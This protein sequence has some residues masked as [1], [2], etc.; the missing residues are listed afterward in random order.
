MGLSKG[1]SFNNA[2]DKIAAAVFF[3]YGSKTILYFLILYLDK[4]FCTKLKYDK[5][6]LIIGYSNIGFCIL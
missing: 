5:L 6:V 2:V 3:L 4:Y 1:T